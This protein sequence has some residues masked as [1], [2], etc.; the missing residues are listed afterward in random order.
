MTNLQE[1]PGC[2]SALFGWLGFN[3][4]PAP[5]QS[6]KMPKAPFVTPLTST[7]EPAYN[8]SDSLFTFRE[9]VFYIALLDA[10]GSNYWTF[11][12]VRLAD[13]IWLPKDAPDHKFHNNAIQCKHVDYLICERQTYRP[14]L[15]IELDDPSHRY[16]DTQ[17]RDE[18]KNRTFAKAG[19]PLLRVTM[20]DAY[21]AA[22]LWAEIK[23]KLMPALSSEET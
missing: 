19:L 9:R 4:K 14:L 3:E 10:V 23:A 6:A 13:F 1:K 15:A 16:P 20:A 8:K 5:A 21:N 11:A 17:V 7:E 12:K 18:F 2:L 22:E